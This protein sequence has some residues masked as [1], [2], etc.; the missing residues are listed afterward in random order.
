MMRQSGIPGYGSW[1]TRKDVAGAGALFDIGVHMLDLALHLVGFPQVE[2]VRGVT[3]AHLGPRRVGL[4]AWG[5]DARR[6]GAFEVDDTVL[7]TLA[8]EGGATVRLHVAWASFGP[9]EERV[10]L[11]GTRGGADRCA[12]LHGRTRPLRLYTST[13]TGAIVESSPTVPRG[14]FWYEGVK[15][16]VRAV[17]GEEPLGVRPEQAIEVLRLLELIERSSSAGRELAA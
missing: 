14:M 10:M 15:Q 4:S 6:R 11:Q 7:A 3:G 17:R 8:L 2:R 13:G 1:F 9:E 12:Q 5:V 16:F